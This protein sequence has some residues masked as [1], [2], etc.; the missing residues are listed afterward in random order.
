M[1]FKKKKKMFNFNFFVCWR[2]LGLRLDNLLKKN[3]S[4]EEGGAVK[5]K[6]KKK[7]LSGMKCLF[8]I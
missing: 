5:I 2:L 6:K 8:M 3:F 4:V 1:P 7:N